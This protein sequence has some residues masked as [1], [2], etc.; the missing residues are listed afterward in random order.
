MIAVDEIL[1]VLAGGFGCRAAWEG[2]LP[3]I[4]GPSGGIKAVIVCP[5]SGLRDSNP[6]LASG[7]LQW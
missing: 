7:D 1:I 4:T 2:S 3:M 6:R 5:R